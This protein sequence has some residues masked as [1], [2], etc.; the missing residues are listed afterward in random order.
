LHCEGMFER[1][2]FS[3]AGCI[4]VRLVRRLSICVFAPYPIDGM[5]EDRQ[6]LQHRCFAGSHKIP[7]LRY[8][9]S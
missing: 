3:V 8:L 4:L 2:R 7:C 1:R 9:L 6:E 5:V